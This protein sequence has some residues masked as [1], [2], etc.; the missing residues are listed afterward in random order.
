MAKKKASTKTPSTP[1]DITLITIPAGMALHRV[2][3]QDYGPTEFNRTKKGSARF[4]P[5][6]DERGKTIPTI[7]AGSTFECAAMETVFHDV[8]YTRGLKTVSKSKLVHRLYSVV[9]TLTD[10]NLITLTSIPLRRLG[11]ERRDL[12]D[13]D[14][15]RYP[16]TRQFAEAAHA[17]EKR[18]QGIIWVSRQDDT[19]TSVVL[20]GD[21][22]SA[23]DLRQIAMSR[24]LTKDDATYIDVLTLAAKIGANIASV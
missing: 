17:Q 6:F 14:A 21:R 5:I 18:A 9:E 20:F 24:D 8:P 15:D 22:L 4:S 23:T 10:L 1:L 16:E 3:H 2:H 13:T 11:I 12:I 7:Y 19:A